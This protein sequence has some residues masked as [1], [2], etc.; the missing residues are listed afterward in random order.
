MKG[1]P[2]FFNDLV[3]KTVSVGKVGIKVNGEAGPCLCTHQG[4]RQG[5]PL[6]FDLA[7]DVQSILVNRAVDNGLLGGLSC[8]LLEK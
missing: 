3:M 6:L 4:L 8:H 1:F 2:S 5:D 7:G